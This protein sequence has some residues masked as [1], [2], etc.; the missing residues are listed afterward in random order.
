MAV[1]FK[2]LDQALAYIEKKETAMIEAVKDVL[3]NTATNV[4][5]QAI[6][7]APTQWEGYPLNIK[8]KI[9][10]KSSNNGLLWQVGVDVPTTGEQWEAWMEFGTGLSAE[11][12]LKN[13]TYSEEVRTLARTYF[14]NGKGRI[15][16]QP[17]LMPAFYRNS[18]N[19][20]ND[21]VDEINK[22]LK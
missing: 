16:G 21:M 12:I 3:A 8:Q 9:D 10:K 20:V 15:V 1:T 2:G 18:A 14:R 5:K 19:L 4:E 6:T 17:Y 7:S 13:P 11:Q 22:V